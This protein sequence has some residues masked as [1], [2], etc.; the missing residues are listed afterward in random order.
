M[1]TKDC[2]SMRVNLSIFS[3][4]VVDTWLVYSAIKNTPV[5]IYNQKEFYAVLAEELIDNSFGNR[6]RPDRPRASPPA[7]FQDAC[8]RRTLEFADPRAGVLYH[9]TPTKRLKNYRGETTTFR[10][11][12]RC[13]E[14]Q[15]KMTWQCSDCGDEGKRRT[16]AQPELENGAF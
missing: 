10:Y 1:E 5:V 14:C 13:K 4:I 16:F 15:Q 2:W 6:G 9:L 12:G 3:M 7:S 8:I 11:Q